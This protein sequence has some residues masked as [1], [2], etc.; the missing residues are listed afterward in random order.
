MPRSAFGSC[1]VKRYAV[2]HESPSAW[3]DDLE[4]PGAE[5]AG[6]RFIRP[7]Q[8]FP[9][10]AKLCATMTNEIEGLTDG[11]PEQRL[12]GT[13]EADMQLKEHTKKYISSIPYHVSVLKND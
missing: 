9:L 3:R 13:K 1:G 7:C 10:R 4:E 6:R 8:I 2:R 12:E 11:Q 5:R